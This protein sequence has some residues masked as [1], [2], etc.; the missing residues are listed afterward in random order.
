[1]RSVLVLRNINESQMLQNMYVRFNKHINH[2][3]CKT[4]SVG[5]LWMSYKR[6]SCVWSLLLSYG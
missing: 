3:F 4:C 6:T 1:M 2:K 5:W